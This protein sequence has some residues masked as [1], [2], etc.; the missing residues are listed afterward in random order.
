ME[1]TILF[2]IFGL[3]IGSFL[4]VVICRMAEG[5]TLMGRSVCRS[6]RK[7]IA[8][9]DNIP[10]FSYLVLG[11][12]CRQC[13]ERI[14]WQYPTVELLTGILYGLVGMFFFSPTPFGILEALWL[15]VLVSLFI[16]I[17][18]YDLRNM[19]I[20][21]T[22]LFLGIAVALIYL[23]ATFFLFERAWPFWTTAL[24]TGLMGAAIVGGF[25]FL[26]VFLSHEK[27]MGWGDVW[28]GVLAGLAVGW[29]L[30]F[31]LLTLSFALGAAVGIGLLAL[32]KKSM[33]AQLPFAPFLV[34]GT[35]VTLFLER[36]ASWLTR[37]FLW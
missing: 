30:A 19:E 21:V 20:P 29:Q 35:L 2:F 12:R 15:L 7:Q 24:G 13:E 8:W 1:H 33:Q 18:F 10:V 26:L 9:Y 5:E 17:A 31:F 16:S 22:L 3:L 34:S 37:F 27:W 25:F 4:N 14:S 28:L 23:S 6:C 11:G 32:R 36:T